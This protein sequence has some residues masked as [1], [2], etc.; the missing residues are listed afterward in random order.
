VIIDNLDIESIPIPP[1]KTHP[2]LI[3]NSDTVLPLA[4]SVKRL[5]SV[6]W[7]HAQVREGDCGIEKR[8]FYECS[9]FQVGWKISAPA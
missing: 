3:I 6:P 9:S 5:Q 4:T 7:R 2:V 1:N 8:K